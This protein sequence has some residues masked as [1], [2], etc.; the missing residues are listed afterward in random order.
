[1]QIPGHPR[2]EIVVPVKNEEHD[3]G[4]NIRRLRDFL[5]TAY[6]FPAEVCI[7]DNGSTDATY[8]IGML[9]A[10]ELSGVRIVRLEH[11]KPRY[12]EDFSD[13][14]LAQETQQ[15]HAM[16]LPSAR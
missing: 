2:V 8:E 6:P 1:M 10:T 9:L 3:L 12:G 5:D 15:T 7:A 16:W 4:P 13:K 11:G 14:T